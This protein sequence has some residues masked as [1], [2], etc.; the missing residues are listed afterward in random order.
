MLQNHLK[1]KKNKSMIKKYCFFTIMI[2]MISCKNQIVEKEE[3][4]NGVVL[5]KCNYIKGSNIK[6][7][8]CIEFSFSGDTIGKYIFKKGKL[9]GKQY[10]YYES[11]G[12]KNI[13]YYSKDVKTGKMIGYYKDGSLKYEVEYKN[14]SLWGIYKLYDINGVELDNGSFKHGKGKVNVYYDSGDIEYS[15]N[16]LNG[17]PNGDWEYIT[18]TG[19]KN[20]IKYNNGL[21]DS[22]YEIMFY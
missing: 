21:D 6:H 5:S 20:I 17:K 8:K 12:Y 15:G 7:G 14:G 19:N 18:D 13:E 11:G 3:I 9:D 16:Y 10:Y 22:G 1:K 2:L 4:F